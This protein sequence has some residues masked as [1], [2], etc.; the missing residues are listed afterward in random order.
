MRGKLIYRG[1]RH[2]RVNVRTDV[3]EMYVYTQLSIYSCLY[4]YI[5]EHRVEQK[6]RKGKTKLSTMMGKIFHE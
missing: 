4:M 1:N 3:V 6:H 2:E 5:P